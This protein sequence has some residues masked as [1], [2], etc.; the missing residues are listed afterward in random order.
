MPD[1]GGPGPQLDRIERIIQKADRIAKIG[2]VV[3][4]I[5]LGAAVVALIPFLK[6]ILR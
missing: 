3:S 2:L 1:F 5:A 6:E 4:I